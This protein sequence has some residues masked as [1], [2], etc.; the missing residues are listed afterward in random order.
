MDE[1][2][3]VFCGSDS[4]D[5]GVHATRVVLEDC[6]SMAVAFASRLAA[7]PVAQASAETVDAKRSQV[8]K[9]L[10]C[11]GSVTSPSVTSRPSRVLL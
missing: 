5:A 6:T 2:I 10:A 9:W 4:R 8:L 3:V 1:A 7:S 11:T